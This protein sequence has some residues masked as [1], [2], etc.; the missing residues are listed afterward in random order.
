ML[1]P[2]RAARTCQIANRAQQIIGIDIAANFTGR[3]CCRQQGLKG[4]FELAAEIVGKGSKGRITG[5]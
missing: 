5:M 1:S 2:V 4:W 3:N